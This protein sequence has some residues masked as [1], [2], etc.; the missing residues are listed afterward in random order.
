MEKR[1]ITQNLPEQI[2]FL[3]SEMMQIKAIL[4]QQKLPKEIPKYLSQKEV[5]RYLN[6]QGFCISS[7]KLYKLTRQNKMPCHRMGTRLYFIPS[8]LEEWVKKQ[9][10]E[11]GEMS[12]SHSIQNII[13]SAQNKH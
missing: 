5:L 7:S 9:F 3:I 2:D 12:G 11:S 13:K 10:E 6:A 8:E 4:L 1:K